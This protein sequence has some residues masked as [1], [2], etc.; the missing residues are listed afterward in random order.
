MKIFVKQS[1]FATQ[2]L[3]LTCFMSSMA[4]AAD[5]TGTWRSIDDK[6]GFAK[7]I[8]R[9]EKTA[10]GTYSGTIEKVLTH[11]GY[12]PKKICVNCP[13]PFTDKPIEGLN[14]IWG[15]VTTPSA[16]GVYDQGKILDPLSGKIYR[17]KL[18]L[19]A[20]G[21]TLNVRGYIGFSMF[22][23]SQVWQRETE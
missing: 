5:V 4:L 6:T 12:I 16:S 7:S 21:Q 23:R 15:L 17:A 3:A 2:V 10:N 20:N 19:G 22:G 14:I 8:I 1:L 9:I 18:T 11:E 13:A